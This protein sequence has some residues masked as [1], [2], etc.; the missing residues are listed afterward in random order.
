MSQQEHPGHHSL[1]DQQ[2]HH[3]TS[4]LTDTNAAT[5]DKAA[6]EKAGAIADKSGAV[7]DTA[8][9][10]LDKAE[11]AV[12]KA[13]DDMSKPQE[14][15]EAHGQQPVNDEYLDLGDDELLELAYASIH[16]EQDDAGADAGVSKTQAATAAGTPASSHTAEA[17]PPRS[18]EPKG[19]S[20]LAYPTLP[21]E[22]DM[23][24]DAVA[25]YILWKGFASLHGSCVSLLDD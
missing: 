23:F 13:G 4:A 3:N 14:L 25:T 8:G 6:V 19:E 11:A 12:D 24:I 15:H 9:A 2:L 10:T 5:V 20:G 1:N 18:A 17:L 21:V 7:L 16:P 22:K